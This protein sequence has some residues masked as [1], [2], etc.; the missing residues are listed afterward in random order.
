MPIFVPL[1]LPLL[2]L[3]FEGEEIFVCEDAAGFDVTEVEA[4][5]LGYPLPIAV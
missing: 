5:V 3:L 2:P 1:L 4:V